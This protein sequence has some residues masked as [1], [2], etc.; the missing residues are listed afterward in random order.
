MEK[1]KI[2]IGVTCYLDEK[3][4]EIKSVPIYKAWTPELQKG[5]D[6]MLKDFA[7]AI[8]PSVQEF[9]KDPKHITEYEEWQKNK[10]DK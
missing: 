5:H 3:G 10:K 7:R 6:D 2:Q 9:Y 4:K 8:L 1:R